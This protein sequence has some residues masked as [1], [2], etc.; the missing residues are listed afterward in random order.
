MSWVLG[1]TTVVGAAAAVVGLRRRDTFWLGFGVT[2]LAWVSLY[3]TC[4]GWQ[5]D[6]Y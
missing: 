3:A 2:A 4:A 6:R 5:C 1:I